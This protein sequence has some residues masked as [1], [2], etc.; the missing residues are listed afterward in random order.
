MQPL[1]Q[2]FLVVNWSNDTELVPVQCNP[3]EISFSKGV[4]IAEI[5]I[6]GLASPLLQ[7]VRGQDETVTMDLFFDTTEDGMGVGATSVTKY[8]DQ[9]YSL[10]KIDPKRHAPPIC[11]LLW[12][13][14]FPGCNA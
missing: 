12:N 4:Q 2:A 9:I 13:T 6:P 7:F 1:Q 5:A 11:T 14:K 8:T 3:T 10:V